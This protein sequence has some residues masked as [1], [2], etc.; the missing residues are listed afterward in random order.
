MSKNLPQNN[1]IENSFFRISNISAL[2][3]HAQLI[4]RTVIKKLFGHSSD[5]GIEI[6]LSHRHVEKR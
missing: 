2:R 4:V 1:Q 3:S 5:L 6:A